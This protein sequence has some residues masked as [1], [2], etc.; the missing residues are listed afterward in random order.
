MI[1]V[2][3]C[4]L[5]GCST[6]C[7]LSEK[8]PLGPPVVTGTLNSSLLIKKQANKQDDNYLAHYQPKCMLSF[9]LSTS[10]FTSHLTHK[11][12]K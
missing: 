6:Y 3:C 8:G 11:R 5:H 12:A 10:C 7:E 2:W 9:F 4:V 1:N